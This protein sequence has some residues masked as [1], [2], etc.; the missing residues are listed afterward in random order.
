[1]N[2]IVITGNVVEVKDPAALPPARLVEAQPPA[3]VIGQFPAL[4]AHMGAKGKKRFTTFFT[5]NIRNK[6]TREAYFR[7]TFRFFEWCESLGLEI[8]DVES[9]HVSTYI[10]LLMQEK[11]KSS[12]K[13]ALAAIRML[14]DWLIVGQVV[15]SNPAH[16]VR[17]P[18]HVVT[19]GLTPILDADQMKLLL[20]SIDTTSVVGLRDR[21]LIGVMTATF[22]RVEAVLGMD[23]KDYFQDG[24]HWGIRLHEK[25]GKVITMPV[26]QRLEEY[27]DAYVQAAGG[28]NAF[29]FEI[30]KNGRPTKKRAFFRTTRGRSK[31][32]TAKRMTR[33]DSWAMVKR[34]AKA[35]GITQ[36]IGN[37][38]FRG[39][40]ITNYLENGGDLREAQR[41][42][43]HSNAKTTG[44]Y[45]RRDQKITRGEV[46]RITILG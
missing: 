27:L 2:K 30:G 41:M 1:M 26:Q 31:T 20:D 9:F 45:D 4:I 17:G 34:R 16:A 38:S 32:L 37:H 11:S 14:F 19:E 33:Q 5:D 8:S 25:N 18:K 28:T 21:A 10:E 36:E 29:P 12:V 42:A 35:A 7:A 3:P 46:E 40:G 43:G 23:I 44:L 15:E 6:N 24:K 22:G 39:T 13:Q